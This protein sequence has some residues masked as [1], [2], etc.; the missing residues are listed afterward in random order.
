MEQSAP[1]TRF[2]SVEE[3]EQKRCR[4]I[5]SANLEEAEELQRAPRR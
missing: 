5:S 4:L 3:I 2:T 1:V